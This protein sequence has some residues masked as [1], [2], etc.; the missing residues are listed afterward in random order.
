MFTQ[1][2]NDIESSHNSTFS[3]S[4][5]MTPISDAAQSLAE[6]Q[7]MNGRINIMQPL[8]TKARFQLTEKINL[9]NKPTDYQNAVSCVWEN[10]VLSQVFF[11]AGNIKI[12]QNAIREGVYQ[13]SQKQYIIPN[14][15]IEQLKI[16][17]RS[18][19]L[20]NARHD[21]NNITGQVAE[22]NKLVLDYCVP[23]VH[24]EAEGYKK[25]CED[26][27]TLVQP[28]PRSTPA[29]RDYRQLE[30]RRPGF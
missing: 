26:A 16:V 2:L 9:R 5:S 25:F 24:G 20:Q 1:N 30:Y 17:M 14:Q 28:L 18:V 27:S 15:N 13:K 29:D 10:N 22:L 19:Y 21:E 7:R 8:D 4:N 3:Q 6:K 12:L 23:F 11:C